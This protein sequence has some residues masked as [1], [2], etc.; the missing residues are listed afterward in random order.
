MVRLLPNTHAGV[1][2][3][4]PE[5]T[6]DDSRSS[7][8]V[9]ASLPPGREATPGKPG[10]VHAVAVRFHAG[11]LNLADAAREL[12]A[13]AGIGATTA[14]DWLREVGISKGAVPRNLRK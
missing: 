1:E 2:I 12:Q 8:S 7:A 5:E 10:F 6:D 4:E 9:A 11:H 14:R 3:C 13:E